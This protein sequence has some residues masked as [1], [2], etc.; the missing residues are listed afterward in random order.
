[1]YVGNSKKKNK[2]NG[3][4]LPPIVVPCMKLF[5]W[6]YHSCYLA[7]LNQT[8][9]V[10]LFES[11]Q[12]PQGYRFCQPFLRFLSIFTV[13]ESKN[14]YI[15]AVSGSRNYTISTISGSRIFL[16]ISTISGSRNCSVFAVS[17]YRNWAISTISGGPMDRGGMSA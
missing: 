3:F 16:S 5:C 12:L 15:F 9:I 1:M 11:L 4:D 7:N 10:S 8:L 14:C 2:G 17:G 13:S 6:V